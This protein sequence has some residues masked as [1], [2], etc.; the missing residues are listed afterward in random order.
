MEG[1]FSMD[2]IGRALLAASS[3][4]SNITDAHGDGHG[5]D[6]GFHVPFTFEELLF[7]CTTLIIIFAFGRLAEFLGLPGLI[8]HIVAGILVGPHGVAIAPKPDALMLAGELGLVL[9][10]MEAGMEVDLHQLQV[11]LATLLSY[12]YPSSLWGCNT[13]Q[14]V[15]SAVHAVV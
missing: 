6:G 10:V 11:K 1:F 4:A 8:G 2:H 3:E 14:T 15:W 7:L 9:M 13:V 12:N 5:G